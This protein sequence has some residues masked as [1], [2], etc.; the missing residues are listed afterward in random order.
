MLKLIQYLLPEEERKIA[1]STRSATR[2]VFDDGHFA[3]LAEVIKPIKGAMGTCK[4][5]RKDLTILFWAKYKFHITVCAW[6]EPHRDPKSQSYLTKHFKHVQHLTI[7]IDFTRVAFS[8]LPGTYVLTKDLVPFREQLQRLVNAIKFRKDPLPYL[9][10]MCRRYYGAREVEETRGVPIQH[11]P[12]QFLRSASHFEDLRGGKVSAVRMSGFTNAYTKE[13]LLKLVFNYDARSAPASIKHTPWPPVSTL[14]NSAWPD[15]PLP[16]APKQIGGTAY[17]VQK[18][19]ESSKLQVGFFISPQLPRAGALKHFKKPLP[20]ILI[21]TK[22]KRYG[23][24][25]QVPVISYSKPKP[26]RPKLQRSDQ[27]PFTPQPDPSKALHNRF[28]KPVLCIEPPKQKGAINDSTKSAAKVDGKPEKV[29]KKVRFDDENIKET[30]KVRFSDENIKETK[31]VRFSDASTKETKMVKLN[32]TNAKETKKQKK[33][34]GKKKKEKKN[35]VKKTQLEEKNYQDPETEPFPSFEEEDRSNT[36]NYIKNNNSQQDAPETESVQSLKALTETPTFRRRHAHSRSE[37]RFPTLKPNFGSNKCSSLF[38]ESL[39]VD[40]YKG[41]ENNFLHETL[42]LLNANNESPN[43][44]RSSSD[45]K[46]KSAN[47]VRSSITSCDDATI[48]SRQSTEIGGVGGNANGPE[49]DVQKFGFPFLATTLYPFSDHNSSLEFVP[50][51][52]IVITNYLKNAEGWWGGS[53]GPRKGYFPK[54]FVRQ[55]R[56]LYYAIAIFDYSYPLKEGG[57]DFIT[58]DRIAVLANVN[59][60]MICLTNFLSYRIWIY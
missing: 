36:I 1:L 49:Y 60:G 25:L 9:H 43:L 13:L 52:I 37:Y 50:G 10:L 42:A 41:P 12:I 26:V 34:K 19:S 48:G 57:F 45:S 15:V 16:P 51:E 53:I 30:K 17:Q 8:R 56:V 2:E 29:E 20:P 33:K 3:K 21:S 5:L 40:Q 54:Q 6:I 24:T 31:K 59:K 46:L 28:R 7:E 55:E 18:P 22:Q 23:A 58:E 27:R 47:E 35:K 39:H 32:N 38:R 44:A 4:K 11:C 14:E